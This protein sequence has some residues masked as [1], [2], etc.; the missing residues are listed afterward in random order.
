MGL[1]RKGVAHPQWQSALAWRQ[2]ESLAGGKTVPD[3][4]RI[5]SRGTFRHLAAG[6]PAEIPGDS[7]TDLA[8]PDTGGPHGQAPQGR[9]FDTMYFVL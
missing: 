7:A 2:S 5:R 9:G 1:A 3:H 8:K 4:G 6:T